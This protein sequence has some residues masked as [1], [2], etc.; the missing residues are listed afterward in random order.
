MTREARILELL[1]LYCKI[2]NI[3]MDNK[4]YRAK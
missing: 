4:T 1:I 3:K 2:I